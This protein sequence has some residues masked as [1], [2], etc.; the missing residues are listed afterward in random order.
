MKYHFKT[1]TE[2]RDRAEQGLLWYLETYDRRERG[3][4]TMTPTLDMPCRLDT[5]WT[6]DHYNDGQRAYMF[7]VIT[8]EI[9]RRREMQPINPDPQAARVWLA[10]LANWAG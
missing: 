2:A 8:A 6:L 4:E 1:R 9:I 3:E 10:A 5:S 7:A